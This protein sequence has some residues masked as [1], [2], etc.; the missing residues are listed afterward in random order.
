MTSVP[1]EVV[2]V[3]KGQAWVRI[4]E[5]QGGCGRCD[6]P[7]GCR[8]MRITDAFGAP[9]QVFVLPDP[10]GLHPGDRVSIAIPDGAPLRA[11]LLS[12]GLGAGLMLAGAAA[13]NSLAGLA[14]G[15]LGAGL[16]AL[17]GL[18]LAVMINRILARSRRWR[19]GL[20]MSLLRDQ[21]SCAH[22]Q[23]S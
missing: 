21:A 14:P 1:A 19:G 20:N 22:P 11:A 7:G 15:D 23:S 9:K 13:G 16:G 2:R 3:D 18:G 10:F 17:A 4:S 5:R 6:E 8:S 12:Y